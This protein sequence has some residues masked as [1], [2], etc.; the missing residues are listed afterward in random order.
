MRMEGCCARSAA[1]LP[2]ESCACLIGNKLL[3]SSIPLCPGLFFPSYFQLDAGD[4]RNAPED[5]PEGSSPAC[6][7][8]CRPSA[9]RPF[10]KLRAGSLALSRLSIF[11]FGSAICVEHK[12]GLPFPAGRGKGEDLGA[13]RYFPAPSRKI[14]MPGAQN[15]R[16]ALRTL[17]R[18][19]APALYVGAR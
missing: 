10:G 1:A 3:H 11:S 18:R 13:R 8:A 16:Q 12:P 17:T 5:R 7:R 4:W 9:S 14:L 19:C 6:L 2:T 15:R